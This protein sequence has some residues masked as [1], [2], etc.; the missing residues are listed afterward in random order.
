[1]LARVRRDAFARGAPAPVV[2]LAVCLALLGVVASTA[3]LLRPAMSAQDWVYDRDAPVVEPQPPPRDP[4][5]VHLVLVP[6]PDDELSGWASLLEG[7]DLRPLLVVLTH[8]EATTRC[9]ARTL[10]RRLREDL[11]ELRPGPDPAASAEACGRARVAS[12]R[13]ALQEA[14]RHTPAVDLAGAPSRTTQVGGHEVEVVAGEHATLV[15][16]DLGDRRLEADRVEA[17]V[18][19]L[20]EDPALVPPGLELVRVTASAYYV[21]EGAGAGPGACGTPSL[22]PEGARP[23]PYDHP[24]HLAVREAARALA[25]RATQGAWLVTQPFDPAADVHLSLPRDIYEATLGLGPGRPE[26]APRR[27]TYQRVYG[28]L[29]FPDAWR[30][31]DLPLADDEVLFP[32]IQSYEVVAP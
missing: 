29:A 9:S 21:P 27:G 16:A 22:C 24:D 7:E 11:G 15:V 20:L 1:M 3:L 18:A 32:R 31:G 10:E 6:H 26:D 25:P 5:G 2:L 14:A 13:T 17:L 28:W 30:T 19:D 4:D 12:L 8:G 23:Y